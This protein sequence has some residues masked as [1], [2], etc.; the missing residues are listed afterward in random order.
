MEETQTEGPSTSYFY[1]QLSAVVHRPFSHLSSPQLLN[2]CRLT[3]LD[4]SDEKNI[5][6]VIRGWHYF[7]SLGQSC[8]EIG[9]RGHHEFER[10]SD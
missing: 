1:F 5:F 6:L 10:W 8:K 7:L 4:K 9:P 2:S 3:S